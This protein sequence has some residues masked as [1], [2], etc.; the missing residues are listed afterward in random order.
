MTRSPL[1]IPARLP[2]LA[3]LVLALILTG[4]ASE[5]DPADAVEAYYKALVE[6]DRDTFMGLAC[7]NWEGMAL[8]DF[9]SFGAVNASL[10]DLDCMQVEND[11]NEATVTCKGGILVEYD[12][13]DNQLFDL[14]EYTYRVTREDGQ[15]QMCGY[16]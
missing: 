7:A 15:W 1:I 9:D 11:D 4:C 10:V 2:L 8:V 13:E 16:Q 6:K 12:G 14:E 3:L 5:E